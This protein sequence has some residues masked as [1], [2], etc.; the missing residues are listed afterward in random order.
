MNSSHHPHQPS[1][2]AM[3]PSSAPATSSTDTHRQQPTAITKKELYQRLDELR[4]ADQQRFR[5]RLSK[6][7]AERALRAIAE[8][9][10]RAAAR[11][12]AIEQAIP[13]IEFPDELPVSHSVAEISAA[14]AK[15]QVVVIAGETGSGKTTQIPKICLQLGRGRSGLIGHTQPRRLAART[16][17]E[18]I[19]DELGQSIGESVGYAIRFNDRV[20]K[21][22]AVKLMTDGILLAEL[23]RDPHLY[24]YDT[25]IIDEAH[26]RSLNIDF[27]LGYLKR[28][29]PK[30]P[31]LKLIIT[32]ATID[33]E[34]F[35]E[36]FR[37]PRTHEP[38]PIIEVSGRTY[39]VEVRYRPLEIEV[40]GKTVAIEPL[41]G[42]CTSVEELLAEGS[43]DILC[44]FP[45]ERDIRDA[46]D[47]LEKKHWRGVEIVPLFGRLSNQEQHRVFAPHNK[48]RIVL[49]TN[50]AET[51]LT[52]PGIHYV[53]DTGTARISRYSTRTK[54][55]RLP[56]EPISQ[57][58]AN[59]RAGRCGRIADGITIRLYSEEDFAARPEFTDPEI[60]RT[61]LAS[62]I[63]QMS[64]LQ[65][66]TVADFPF[67]QPPEPKAV[68]DGLVLL[69]ELD[70]IAS[71]PAAD[72]APRLT[73]IGRQLARIPVD[74]RLARML[75]EAEKLQCL[76][77]VIILVAAMTLQDVR[78][79]PLEKQQQ[80]DQA[81]ARFRSRTSDF[82]GLLSLWDH[83]TSQRAEL[84]GNQFRKRMKEEFLHF[85]RIREWFDLV[86]QLKDIARDMNWELPEKNSA[87]ASELRFADG[88]FSG[89]VAAVHRA[90]LTGLLSNIG[91]RISDSAEFQ[92][93]RGTKFL[94]FPGSGVAKKPPELV[95]A[96]ELV[97]TSKLW[98][99]GVAAIEPSWVENAAQSLLK[100]QY[101]DPRWSF[102]RGAAVVT[103]RSTLY[104]VPIVADRTISYHRVEP[105]AARSMFIQHALIAGE[106][107]TSHKFFHDNLD[108]LSAAGEYE[109]KARRR[110]IIADEEA[111]FEF[112]DRRIP[113]TV[114]HSKA[115]DGWWK[116]AR[117]KQPDL[118][119]FDPAQLVS[120]E[121]ASVTEQAFPDYWRHG[122]LDFELEYLFEPGHRRDGVTVNIPVPMLASVEAW[123]FEWLV[124]GL[125]EEL[126]T[127]L[128]RGLPK[129]L[130]RS[131]V[132]APDFAA[133][134]MEHLLPYESDLLSQ[135]TTA[136]R[137]LG[138]RGINASDF[139]LEKLPPHLQ[140]TFA[141]IDKRGHIIDSD[142]DLAALQ[143]RQAGK[144][145][146][147][148]TKKVQQ[149]EQRS[150]HEPKPA[151][152]ARR[153]YFSNWT[154]DNLGTI[155]EEIE[156][157]VDAHTVKAYP[158]LT[159]SEQGLCIQYYPTRS[160]ADSAMLT[161][162]LTLLLR[163]L[164]VNTQKMVNGLPLQQRV[165]VDHYPHGGAD[166]L[167]NDARIAA[168]RDLLLARGGPVRSPEK[169]AELKATISQSL[170]GEVR[171]A[172]VTLAP[173]LVRFSKI[174][175]E[176]QQ[177]EGPAI[178][179]MQ[180]QLDFLL[181]KNAISTHGLQ[182]L[183]HLP[184]YL[185]AMEI[186]LADM[187]AD[188]DKDGERQ[189]II[190]DC[191]AYLRNQLRHLPAGAEK[192]PAVAK[193]RWMLEELRVSLFA[194][195]LGT[196]HPVSARRVKKAVDALTKKT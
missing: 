153:E 104:G 87:H 72:A 181:P 47:A 118:L 77:P 94:I 83:I 3:N 40:D 111:L 33:P 177:W 151:K 107:K 146:A 163:E 21:H 68:R 59:Q 37:D 43:G 14:I 73:K 44:F 129:A 55:Q 147:S 116:K 90:L 69:D 121:A 41:D 19:S 50:I 5:R 22:T 75:V 124:P 169:F 8:D 108:K 95:M 1:S 180:Q 70:A 170:P 105:E 97:E 119:D 130:R 144:I 183:R 165:A 112:Y 122:G 11:I 42:L 80:A 92:G 113:E 74:P 179:D 30:R 134:A 115:F 26:E 145:S 178:D 195:R 175:D 66:G 184:R 127:E 38:A 20:G 62:V 16:V 157:D 117:K 132:P 155:A 174:A 110:G 176:L 164:T 101:S 84:S 58:S 39:P 54:V 93:A 143:Q 32:S 23:Q 46:Q 61:N 57:A 189:D 137:S 63:L 78:E 102:K 186:R 60:L 89:D 13:P 6:A 162:T 91:A 141:A 148:I 133:R 24:A 36:H 48:R 106:W 45:G 15:N 131:L 99:R 136:F 135:V 152:P 158:A 173:G 79:R 34:S 182:Q 193:I 28:L 76:E 167:V 159:I 49:A 18:R 7:K 194:Q 64:S 123:P 166:G 150:S 160:A 114:T 29:L 126:V 98:A 156:H 168:L 149:V 109:E 9:L 67:V 138:A 85:M 139:S 191:R 192:S 190:D 52:V 100:H 140:M 71:P 86:R 185:Q 56:I 187:A 120:E 128:I 171:Q 142:K 81:H 103:Q 65:L 125:R 96:S 161:A 53:I 88:E 154:A 188:P 10:E 25:I 4:L 2:P 35:A 196:A 12:P 51:S 172:V 31:E 82:L 17:A 27:L